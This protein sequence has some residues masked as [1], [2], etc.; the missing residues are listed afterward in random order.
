MEQPPSMPKAKQR[1]SGMSLYM[2][3]YIIK[4][5]RKKKIRLIRWGQSS[6]QQS[7]CIQQTYSS[8][9]TNVRPFKW[10]I[11]KKKIGVQTGVKK[12]LLFI[13]DNIHIGEKPAKT[14]A[15][16]V[17]I[18]LNQIDVDPINQENRNIR[19]TIKEIHIAII[20]R[21]CPQQWRQG[22]PKRSK[23]LLNWFCPVRRLLQKS[24]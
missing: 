17:M 24:W 23:L 10:K 13:A 12:R 6:L 19:L 9:E 21:C 7:S 18:L 8:W 14:Q 22:V 11:I 20:L 15:M 16:F 2:C 5:E 1:K 4:A 3:V